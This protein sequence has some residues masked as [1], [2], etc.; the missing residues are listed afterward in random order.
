M[1]LDPLRAG[2]TDRPVRLSTLE[3]A[4]IEARLAAAR[5]RAETLQPFSPAWDAAMAGID[6][7]EIQLGDSHRATRAPDPT[8]GRPSGDLI[9]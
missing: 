3:S 9:S 8:P 6:D 4:T 1:A 7:L 5:E 2:R